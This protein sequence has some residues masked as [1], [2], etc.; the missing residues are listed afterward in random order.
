MIR[1]ERRGAGGHRRQWVQAGDPTRGGRARQDALHQAIATSRGYCDWT[2]DR[3]GW[4]VILRSPE[5][6]EFSGKT[7]DEALAWRLVWLLAPA[8]RVGTVLLE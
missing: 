3:A 2:A 1:T 4:V 7:L 5:G 8:L 6:Q